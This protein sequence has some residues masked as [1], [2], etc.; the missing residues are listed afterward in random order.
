LA[1]HGLRI[2]PGN[3]HDVMMASQLIE[4]M[5]AR[6]KDFRRVA[7]RYDKLAQEFRC[8]HP[9][10]C[11]HNLVAQLS[12]DHSLDALRADY[13]GTGR[14]LARAHYHMDEIE[15]AGPLAGPDL[16]RV[17]GSGSLPVC[18]SITLS[19]SRRRSKGLMSICVHHGLWPLETGRASR[20]TRTTARRQWAPSESSFLLRDFL[21]KDMN[22][23]TYK[24]FF[25][26]LLPKNNIQ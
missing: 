5:F 11:H 2:A 12:P 7:T 21:R 26:V 24:L 8:W 25:G 10:G 17:S 4:R 9:S 18:R 3:I 6:L 14:W 1:D 15:G 16:A 22:L 19:P 13:C 20:L 23:S